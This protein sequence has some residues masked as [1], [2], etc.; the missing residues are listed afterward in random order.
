[1][2]DHLAARRTAVALVGARLAGLAA[3]G[4]LGG[5]SLEELAASFVHL[6]CNRLLGPDPATERLVLGLLLRTRESLDRAPV[7][8]A[9]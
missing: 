8:P 1:M 2:L 6:H 7:P 5:R 3:A 9:P 4:R